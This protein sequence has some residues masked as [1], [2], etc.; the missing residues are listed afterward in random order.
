MEDPSPERRFAI[1][2]SVVG[3]F[4]LDSGTLRSNELCIYSFNYYSGRRRRVLKYRPFFFFSFPSFA[5]F[6]L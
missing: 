6:A 2:L 3:L 4:A 1:R 5:D